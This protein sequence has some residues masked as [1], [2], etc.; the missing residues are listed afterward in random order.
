MA[1]KSQNIG[2]K[3]PAVFFTEFITKL[4]TFV[5]FRFMK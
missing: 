1:N 5:K 4:S 2:S 3:F